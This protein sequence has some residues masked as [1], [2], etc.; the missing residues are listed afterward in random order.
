MKHLPSERHTLSILVDNE[1]GVLARIV[2]L[3]SAPSGGRR[4]ARLRA[5]GGGVLPWSDKENTPTRA[6]P[7]GAS[8]AS[9]LKGEER[10]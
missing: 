6:A 1:A 8:L 2:G 7:R 9:P 4:L 10:G 5:A 3:F